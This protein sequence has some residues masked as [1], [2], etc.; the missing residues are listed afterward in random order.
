MNM[1]IDTSSLYSGVI[2]A[3]VGCLFMAIIQWASQ[4]H[5]ENLQRRQ[6]EHDREMDDRRH[7]LHLRQKLDDEKK[8]RM[9]V[10]TD[11]CV[12]KGWHVVFLV[13]A[14]QIAETNQ[15]LLEICDMVKERR[16]HSPLEMA[17]NVGLKPEDALDFLRWLT[18]RV[19]NQ[20]LSAE[21]T[22]V[23]WVKI[24]VDQFHADKI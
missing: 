14:P 19:P 23:G 21:H 3:L 5:Q 2:G 15:E 12:S 7:N 13:E 1:N 11:Y 10:I 18:P 6:F 24:M 16:G 9:R 17:I 4:R 22:K 8:G 20:R